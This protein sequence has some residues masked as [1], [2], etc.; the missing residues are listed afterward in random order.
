MINKTLNFPRSPCVELI[1]AAQ[2]INQNRLEINNTTKQVKPNERLSVIRIPIISYGLPEKFHQRIRNIV[3]KSSHE[4][5]IKIVCHNANNRGYHIPIWRQ[6]KKIIVSK[7]TSLVQNISLLFMKHF[8]SS[9]HLFYHKFV[10]I[11]GDLTK[12]RVK[13]K[14]LSNWKM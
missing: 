3:K 10:I 14:R 6:I 12:E 11:K 8:D 7:R 1:Q 2:L 4:K 9:Y 5:G 13:W